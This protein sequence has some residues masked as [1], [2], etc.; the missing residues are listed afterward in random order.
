M[1]SFNQNLITHK[2][3]LLNLAAELRNI[4]KACRIMDFSRDAGGVEALFDVSHKKPNLKNRSK[5]DLGMRKTL[6][7][8]QALV[9]AG[10]VMLCSAHGI[11]E[12]TQPVRGTGRG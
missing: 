9:K 5:A 8:T 12:K 6:D 11:L 10:A 4:S 7:V 3:G 1:Q 2:T